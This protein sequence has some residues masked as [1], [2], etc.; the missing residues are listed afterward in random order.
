MTRRWFWPSF[1]FPGVAWLVLLFLVPTYAVVA[2]AFGT[3][4]PIF[5]RSG[6]GLE[7]APLAVRGDEVVL[8]GL[9]PGHTFWIVSVRTYRLR[10]DLAGRLPADRLSGRVL[11]RAARGT[12]E[13]GAARAADHPVL[14]QLPDADARLGRAPA[15]GRSRE[16]GAG[17]PRG[18]LAPAPLARR[19]AVVGHLRPDL[20][21]RPVPD[22]AALRGA[23]PDRPER[24]RGRPRP[25]RQPLPHLPARDPAAQPERDPRRERA[26]RAA[27]VRRLLHERRHLQLAADLD[28]RQPDQPLLPGGH[29]RRPSARRS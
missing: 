19:Q 12:D 15:P 22:P 11:P 29:A 25:R 4:D 24:A 10:R 23:R 27:D 26:D 17:G 8:R 9:Q 1:A 3:V 7:P 5:G 20:R 18:H 28:D 2:V 16:P 21:L 6:S 13:G 14:G